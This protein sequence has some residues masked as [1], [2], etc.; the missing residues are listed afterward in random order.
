MKQGF[1]EGGLDQLGRRGRKAQAYP[2]ND[3][4]MD[5][6]TLVRPPHVAANAAGQDHAYGRARKKPQ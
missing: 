1:T 6:L 5:P 2:E 4:V 3:S